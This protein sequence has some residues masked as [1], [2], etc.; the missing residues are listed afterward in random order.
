MA[1]TCM[2]IIVY[3]YTPCT[4]PRRLNK[5][6]LSIC[7]TRPH[8]LSKRFGSVLPK[9]SHVQRQPCVTRVGSK[10]AAPEKFAHGMLGSGANTNQGP[11][12][13]LGVSVFGQPAAMVVF[14][15]VSL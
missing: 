7:L 2:Y 9:R 14:C 15:L 12:P 4:Q 13:F 10:V 5:L 6:C 11:I 1:S 8:V 3:T